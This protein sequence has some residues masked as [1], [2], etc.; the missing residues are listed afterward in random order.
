VAQASSIPVPIPAGLGRRVLAIL[1]DWVASLLVVRLIFPD[2]QYPG[3]D[4][5]VAILGVFY[6]EVTLFTWLIGSSFGQRIVGLA[7]IREAGGRLGLPA[8]ALRT[9][10]ICLVI[11]ALVYDSQGRG[12]QD[13]AAGSRVVLRKSVVV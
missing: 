9:F 5:A 13:R 10:L 6:L 12:L 2:M 1:I 8:I 3:N 4:S 7:V 11:P